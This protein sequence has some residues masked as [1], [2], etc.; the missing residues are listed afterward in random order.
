MPTFR[1]GRGTK[2]LVNEWDMSTYF[3]DASASGTAD[4]GETTAFGSEVKTYVI[5]M[6]D[7]R[8]SLGGMFSGDVQGVDETFQAIFGLEAAA[9]LTYA[10]EGLALGRRVWGMTAHETSYQVQGSVSDIVAVSA[11]FQATGGLRSGYS[12]GDPATAVT[13]TGN[14]TAVDTGIPSSTAGGWGMLHALAS[15][16]VGT[17]TVALQHSTTFGGTYTTIP[18]AT[19]AVLGA[20]VEGSSRV[21]IAPGVTINQFVRATYTF[22]SAGGSFSAHV[23]FM[24]HVL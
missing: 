22:G 18:G 8:V 12:L 4:T 20:G 24:R 13:A 1:H 14:G 21:D 9:N 10:P 7:G 11:E 6:T 15:T 23:N 19:F 3:K 16:S 5:G 17:V 2:V